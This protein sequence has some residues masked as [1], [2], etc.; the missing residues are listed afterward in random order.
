MGP[1]LYLELKKNNLENHMFFFI[2]KF[3]SNYTLK[4][5]YLPIFPLCNINF[6]EKKSC[7]WK[8]KQLSAMYWRKK[9]EK[10]MK[11]MKFVS[12]KNNFKARWSWGHI[13]FLWIFWEKGLTLWGEY[14]RK[15]KKSKGKGGGL[16]NV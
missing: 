1:Q 8:K 3:S 9:M 12:K 2:W 7:P 13:I 4:T 10:S 15:E 5:H 16:F 6:N 11:S 14:K